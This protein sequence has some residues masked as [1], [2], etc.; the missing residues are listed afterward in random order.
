[1]ASDARDGRSTFLARRTGGLCAL[2][3]AVL[4]TCSAAM[5]TPAVPPAAAAPSAEG[6]AATGHARDGAMVR[7]FNRD[8]VTLRDEFLGRTP[9]IRARAAEENIE[10]IVRKPGNP[11]LRYVGGVAVDPRPPQPGE[12]KR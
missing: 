4:W 7:Y 1:M 9:E 6:T 12:V 8:I 2:L 3:I 10:R 5:A 11:M